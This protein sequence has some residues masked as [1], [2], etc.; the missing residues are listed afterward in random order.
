MDMKFNKISRAWGERQLLAEDMMSSRD[1][2]ECKEEEE[3]EEERSPVSATC[4]AILISTGT[5]SLTERSE[6]RL[7]A[8]NS[9]SRAAN[10]EVIEI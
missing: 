2:E 10:C 8:S 6:D 4:L 5:P 1:D 9:L 7:E 3:E